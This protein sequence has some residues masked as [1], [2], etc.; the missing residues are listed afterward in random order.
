VTTR[1]TMIPWDDEHYF[2]CAGCGDLHNAGYPGT[3]CLAIV[4]GQRIIERQLDQYGYVTRPPE[5]QILS[6]LGQADLQKICSGD[7][8]LIRETR[9]SW[10]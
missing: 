1:E 6:R 8:S 10:Y 2:A 9:P 7:P 5:M 4:A 3:P